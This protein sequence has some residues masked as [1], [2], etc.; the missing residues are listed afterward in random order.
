MLF[1]LTLFIK[2]VIKAKLFPI[3]LS[4]PHIFMKKNRRMGRKRKSVK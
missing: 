3:L 1:H 2:F 4:S